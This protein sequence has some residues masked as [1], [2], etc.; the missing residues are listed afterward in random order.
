MTNSP[1]EAALHIVVL[2]C[3]SE[4][5][6]VAEYT[7]QLFRKQFYQSV[8]ASITIVGIS[9]WHMLTAPFR[10]A[11]VIH[12]QH[13]FFTFDRFAGVTAPVYYI[14]LWFWSRWLHYRIVSTIHSAYDVRHLDCSLPHLKRFAALFPLLSLYLRLHLWLVVACSDRVILL[15]RAGLQNLAS[16]IPADVMQCKARHIHLGNYE[17]HIRMQPHGLLRTRIGLAANENLF[18]L[19]GFAFPPKGYEFAIQAVNVLVNRWG[20]TDIRLVIVSGETHKGGLGMSYI[21]YLKQLATKYQVSSHVVFTG[22]LANDDPLL[23][24]IFHGTFCFLFPYKNRPFAS[25]ALATTLTTYKP[26]LVSDIPCF[27]EYDGLLTFP[28]ADF[29]ALARRMQD[30]ID[31]PNLARNAGIVSQDNATRFNM[32]NVF[33]Q[34]MTLYRE[35]AGLQPQSSIAGGVDSCVNPPPPTVTNDRPLSPK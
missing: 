8:R 35:V 2:S 22:Y 12:I 9:P 28:E 13:E 25:A 3:T 24:D 21:D 26:I 19:F 15:T 11:Q 4:R 14:W 27:H 10:H 20:R 34:H 31:D 32:K 33:D 1:P 18:T 30:L 29:L 7:R 16:A 6:G 17:S 5:D 23:E